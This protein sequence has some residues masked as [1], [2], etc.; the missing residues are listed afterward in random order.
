MVNEDVYGTACQQSKS[1]QLGKGAMEWSQCRVAL[2][3]GLFFYHMA[4]TFERERTTMPLLTTL[5]AA[6]A[7]LDSRVTLFIIGSHK[8]CQ[9]E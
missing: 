5:N 9:M 3:K 6:A 7:A 2:E 8:T 4:S 1:N